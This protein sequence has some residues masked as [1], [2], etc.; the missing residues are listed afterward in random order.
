ML[1]SE[2]R[3]LSG[4]PFME[5]LMKQT[6]AYIEPILS[7]FPEAAYI[8]DLSHRIIFWNSTAEKITGW[9]SS[10]VLGKS[11]RDGILSH[12]DSQGKSLCNTCF[13]AVHRVL[14][15]SQALEKPFLFF[16]K[17][18]SGEELLLEIKAFPLF[19]SEGKIVG[20]SEIFREV[21]KERKNDILLSRRL[22]SNLTPSGVQRY[23]NYSVSSRFLPQ[24]FVG[25][26][27]FNII[28]DGQ[29]FYFFFGDSEGDGTSAAL[30]S[31]LLYGL[32]HARLKE[33]T[34]DRLSETMKKIHQEFC[35]ITRNSITS[36]MILGYMN[37]VENIFTYTNA[38]HPEIFHFQKSTGKC[39]MLEFNSFFLGV[40][41]KSSFEQKK[42]SV[43][44]GDR[45]LIYSDGAF[46]F[47][48]SPDNRFGQENLLSCFLNL[49]NSN[50][51]GDA[52]L[53]RII[54]HLIRSNQDHFFTDD[55]SLL[56]IESD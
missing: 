42:V 28:P 14:S 32:A 50:L 19:N 39:Q 9:L 20:V 16:T 23:G 7:S 44:K 33:S 41:D 56:V 25:G 13:C 22:I 15:T 43:K 36:T 55:L 45:F 17:N 48:V 4:A 21:D 29:N 51:N 34:P 26:D 46:E 1:G 35:E 30:L 18:K 54:E 37:T 6:L 27:F 53:S 11:C 12:Y 8:T 5:Y 24:S 40:L 49:V 38:G 31:L 3:I 2:V 47:K 10:E 52:L